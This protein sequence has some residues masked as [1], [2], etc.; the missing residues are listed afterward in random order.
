MKSC[1]K[2][3]AELDDP[4]LSCPNCGAS[5]TFDVRLSV[6][7]IDG[8][9]FGKIFVYEVSTAS[10]RQVTI[11]KFQDYTPTWSPDSRT[12]VFNSQ[13]ALFMISL[14]GGTPVRLTDGTSIDYWPSW[15]N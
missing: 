15:F 14:D 6:A 2:C 11:G 3:G 7:Y 9:S 10:V 4:A 8:Q 12:I 5:L 1:S 13:N